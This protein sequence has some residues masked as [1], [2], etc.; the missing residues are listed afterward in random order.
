MEHD[1][2]QKKQVC[3]KETGKGAK[4]FGDQYVLKYISGQ[5][6]FNLVHFLM[7]LILFSLIEAKETIGPNYV[8]IIFD[9][10]SILSYDINFY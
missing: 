3:L 9:Q 2:L 10:K 4:W 6:D 5:S 8:E 1:H 7:S